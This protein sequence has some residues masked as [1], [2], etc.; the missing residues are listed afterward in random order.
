MNQVIRRRDIR[1]DPK[2]PELNNGPKDRMD[3][4]GLASRP[5][6]GP[7]TGHPR[8]PAVGPYGAMRGWKKCPTEASCGF[9]G[10]GPKASK[11]RLVANVPNRIFQFP[12]VG[13]DF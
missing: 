6:V 4:L 13:E 11:A 5:V 8:G 1:A 10:P 3:R 7:G 2:W 12:P 9:R